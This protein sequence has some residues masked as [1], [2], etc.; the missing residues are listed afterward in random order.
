MHDGI[1][2]LQKAAGSQAYHCMH[3]SHK[4]CHP[5]LG[6][7]AF[8][9]T[10][11]T[12]RKTERNIKIAVLGPLKSIKIVHNNSDGVENPWPRPRFW[13][14]R[15]KS[16]A[17]GDGGVW[18]NRGTTTAKSRHRISYFASRNL[19]AVGFLLRVGK[20]LDRI[21]YLT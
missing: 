3:F 20:W 10:H 4:S 11:S 15:R 7:V 16:S 14:P 5:S 12:P 21:E 18:G 13:Q 6:S 17:A 2:A 1:S 8:F 9:T 19:P